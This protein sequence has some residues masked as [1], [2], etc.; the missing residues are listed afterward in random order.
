MAFQEVRFEEGS[1]GSA[2]PNQLQHLAKLL[3]GYQVLCFSVTM[4]TDLAQS[5]G[6][7]LSPHGYSWAGVLEI[8]N[9]RQTYIRFSG[10]HIVH[11]AQIGGFKSNLGFT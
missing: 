2:G 4:V 3:P 5:L 1:G 11:G 6:I 10:S 8:L 9:T 7:W